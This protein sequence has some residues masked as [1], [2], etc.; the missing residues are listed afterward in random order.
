MPELSFLSVEL[1]YFKRA[2]DI[3][4]NVPPMFFFEHYYPKVETLH[5]GMGKRI[6]ED[7]VF[8]LT[9]FIINA[10]NRITSILFYD[11]KVQS[12]K[13]LFSFMKLFLMSNLELVEI[14]HIELS[15]KIG[16]GRVS[17]SGLDI[18]VKKEIIRIKRV[19]KVIEV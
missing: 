16:R 17:I 4:T 14:K 8:F 18:T 19:K 5:V 10:R 13:H 2:S 9:R 7:G 3:G 11:A 12:M 6:R 15:D 1:S